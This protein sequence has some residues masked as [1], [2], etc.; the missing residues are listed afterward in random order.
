MKKYLTIIFVGFA[1]LFSLGRVG[2]E[3]MQVLRPDMVVCELFTAGNSGSV[4]SEPGGAGCSTIFSFDTFYLRACDVPT[5]LVLSLRA[6]NFFRTVK[7]LSAVRSF[8]DMDVVLTRNDSRV[9]YCDTDFI[10]TSYRYFVY[11]LR[12]LLI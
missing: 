8:A 6:G 4:L 1:L 3:R 11:T 2:G 10:K 5:S 12:R 7:F 9:K